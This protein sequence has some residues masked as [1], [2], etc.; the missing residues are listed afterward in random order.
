MASTTE[1]VYQPKGEFYDPWTEHSQEDIKLVNMLEDE[2]QRRRMADT[3]GEQNRRFVANQVSEIVANGIRPNWFNVGTAYVFKILKLARN[4]GNKAL[5]SSQITALSAK[6]QVAGHKGFSKA[7]ELKN[8]LEL[9][10]TK[11][12]ETTSDVKHLIQEKFESVQEKVSEVTKKLKSVSL[13]FLGKVNQTFTHISENTNLAF[14]V[15]EEE[16]ERQRRLTSE[17]EAYAILNALRVSSLLK[18][19]APAFYRPAFE[20]TRKYSTRLLEENERARRQIVDLSDHI[21]INNAKNIAEL[22][23]NKFTAPAPISLPTKVEP[24]SEPAKIKPSTAAM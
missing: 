23:T 20:P 9:A 11:A 4:A 19:L 17:L 5:H 6:L 8:S 18:E 7:Q 21:A 2:E 16:G 3:I 24:V 13:K 15:L 1:I 10:G 22:I 14:A 12:Q